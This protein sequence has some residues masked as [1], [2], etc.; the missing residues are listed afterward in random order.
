MRDFAEGPENVN[1][2]DMLGE[3]RPRRG[4]KLEKYRPRGGAGE[5][6][7]CGGTGQ[8]WSLGGAQRSTGLTRH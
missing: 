1:L 3:H 8:R 4:A 2:V 6:Y 7:L 5:C